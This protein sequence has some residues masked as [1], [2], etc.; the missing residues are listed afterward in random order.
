MY[1]LLYAFL[2]FYYYLGLKKILKINN[3]IAKQN[4]LIFQVD[5]NSSGPIFH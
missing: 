4:N 2:I 5:E 1:E 3:G